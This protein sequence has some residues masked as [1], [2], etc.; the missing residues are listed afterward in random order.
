MGSRHRGNRCNGYGQTSVARRHCITHHRRFFAA[1]SYLRSRTRQ[2]FH[3]ARPSG[4]RKI[5]N[6]YQYHRQRALQRKTSLICSGKDGCPLRC[7]KQIGS[8]RPSSILS[9]NSFQ[10]NKEIRRYLA[11]ERNYGNYQADTSRR[12]QKGSGTPAEFT[13]GIESIYRSPA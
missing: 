2:D 3:P 4:N 13:G 12:I 1:G 8:Y 9:G 5:A 10:Q 7:A 6:D 11:T